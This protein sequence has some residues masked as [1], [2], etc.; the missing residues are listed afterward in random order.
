MMTT[1]LIRIVCTMLLSVIT[2]AASKSVSAAGPFVQVTYSGTGTGAGGTSSSFYGCLQYDSSQTKE[3]AYTFK[4]TNLN[5]ELCYEIGDTVPICYGTVGAAACTSFIINT[6][7]GVL[8]LQAVLPTSPQTL[9]IICLPMDTASGPNTLPSTCVFTD[10]PPATACF[11][12]QNNSTGQVLYSGTIAAIDCNASATAI[13][14]PCPPPENNRVQAKFTHHPPIIFA[15]SQAP[16]I[17]VYAEAPSAPV[18]AYQ[19]RPS[20]CFSGLFSLCSKLGCR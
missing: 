20:R 9:I 16:V 10:P 5:H 8:E 17:P 12:V 19:P 15:A 1:P 6:A 3:A 7:G 13:N 11:K 2:L 4:F 18:Y 14:C